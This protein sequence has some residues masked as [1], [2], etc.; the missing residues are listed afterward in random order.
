MAGCANQEAFA[1]ANYA[2]CQ[3]LGFGPETQYYKKPSI[4]TCV[5]HRCSSN[6]LSPNQYQV[7]PQQF[8]HRR[9]P[10]VAI[11]PEADWVNIGAGSRLLTSREVRCAKAL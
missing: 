3:Q 4:T 7:K 11:D 9:E 8:P 10:L 2:K 5:S 1:A 6:V